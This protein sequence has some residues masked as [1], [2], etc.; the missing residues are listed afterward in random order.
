MASTFIKISTV[1]V[2]ASGIASIEF[3]NIPQTYTDLKIVSSLRNTID[4]VNSTLT[5]N[6]NTSNYSWRQIYGAG[7]S[8]TSNTGTYTS[9]GVLINASTFTSS[10]FSSS[11][12]YIPN[13][14]SSNNKSYS[15]DSVTENN[16][17]LSYHNFLAG[18]WSNSN[19]I[20][21]IKLSPDSGNF[22]Q[23][24]TTTLY[25]IKSS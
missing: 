13:Y 11:D 19:P 10:I 20:T 15:V 2:G 1:T 9:S 7:T 16:A 4:V 6:N 8:A 17:T 24:S 23:Y 3:T 21:T 25:G 5:F 18:L 12:I 22:A 14:T